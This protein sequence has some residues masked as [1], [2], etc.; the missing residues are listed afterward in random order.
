MNKT[1]LS[2]LVLAATLSTSAFADTTPGFYLGANAGTAS[3]D[4]DGYDNTT[5]AGIKIGYEFENRFAIEFQT[6]S[7]E[8]DYQSGSY[9]GDTDFDTLA[10]YGVWRSGGDLFFK[11]KLGFLK[12]EV[13]IT[14]KSGANT[15]SAEADDSGLS[16]GLG[17]GYRITDQIIVE[18]EYTLI[19]A[20]ID[21][22]TLGLAYKF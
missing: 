7:G 17:V 12:E 11:S 20:D 16:F 2:G 8:S 4:T 14:A 22:F 5:M 10:L 19:E 9:S 18:A 13:K 3:I 21:A 1:C 6:L 15:V